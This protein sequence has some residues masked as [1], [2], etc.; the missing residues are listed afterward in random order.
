MKKHIKL[1][2]RFFAVFILG[3][4]AG[5]ASGQDLIQKK[6]TTNDYKLWSKL[7]TDKIS[8][9]AGWISYALRYESHLDTLFVKSTLTGQQYAF[10]GSLEGKFASEEL[11]ACIDNKQN[12]HLVNLS[13]GNVDSISGVKEYDLSSDGSF[14]VTLESKPNKSKILAIRDKNGKM[15]QRIENAN[16]FKM[17]NAGNAVLYSLGQNGY[18]EAGLIKLKQH[19]VKRKI[20]DNSTAEIKSMTWSK[21]GNTSAFYTENSTSI[22]LYCYDCRSQRLSSLKELP[23]ATFNNKIITNDSSIPLKI[24]DDNSAVFFAYKNAVHSILQNPVVEIWKNDDKYIYPNSVLAKSY[25]KPLLAVWY[26]KSHLAR[27]LS[28]E[29]Y[30]W[31]AL[32]GNQKYAVVADMLQYEPQYDNFA[33]LDYY[34]MEVSNGYKELMISNQSGHTQ[35]MHFSPNGSYICY[36]KNDI[37]HLYDIKKKTHSSLTTKTPFSWNSLE[38]PVNR[39]KI[40]FEFYGWSS[41]GKSILFYDKYDIWQFFTDGKQPVRLTDGKE[42][43]IRYRFAAVRQNKRRSN[44]STTNSLTI[45]LKEKNI[46][47]AYDS[48]QGSSGC[49]ILNPEKGLQSLVFADAKIS[50]IRKAAKRDSYCFESEKFDKSPSLLLKSENGIEI[51]TIIQTNVQ[52]KKFYWGHSEMINFENTQKDTLSAALFYPANYNPQVKY[53]LVV[54]IYEKLSHKLHNYVTP[55]IHS[56][57]GFNI[58]HLT[59][60]GYFV[61]MPDIYYERGN[62]GISATQCVESAVKQI[63]GKGVIDSSRVGIMGHSFGGYEVNCIITNSNMFAAA[64]SG[65]G[66]SDN[67]RGYLTVNSEFNNAEIWRFENQQYRMGRSLYEGKDSYLRNSPVF[68]ADKVN[69]PI[70]IW[71]GKNDNNVKPEQSTAFF[72]ALRRLNK[73]SIMLQYPNEAHTLLSKNTQEDLND[74]AMDW[75]DYYLKRD[76]PADWITET[77]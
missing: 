17:N 49:F 69:T 74:K 39:N 71:T 13:K 36:Y 56:T 29:K 44:Y 51:K 50:N 41:D 30:S 32:S 60:N 11:F 77:N 59:G 18:Y 20:L 64:V 7:A 14:L 54:Y 67:I 12:L 15:L 52:Q 73:K 72:L 27:P 38:D 10:A 31:V 6:L 16:D 58:T 62:T 5:P 55:S 26:P 22:C 4:V 8:D 2:Y 45:N 46:L 53:P 21:D 1:V 37:W 33:P 19:I 23:R 9:K 47:E 70:L 24:A 3:L 63:I 28:C 42:K 25:N 76:K 40:S 75:F 43:L 34:I 61:L 35:Y 68:N 66:V 48:K 57:Q 65:A